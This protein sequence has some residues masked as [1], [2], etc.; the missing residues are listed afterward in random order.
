MAK[1]TLSQVAEKQAELL[2]DIK[3]LPA[4]DTS[5]AILDLLKIQ[6]YM[7]HIIADI[8]NKGGNDG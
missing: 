8:I 3:T 5:K 1:F 7:A 2:E 4:T 6:V